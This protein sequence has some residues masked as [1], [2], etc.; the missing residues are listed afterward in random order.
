VLIEK[1][2]VNG[3]KLSIYS[4]D[5]SIL[6][7]EKLP[8]LYTLNFHMQTLARKH[9]IAKGLLVVHDVDANKVAMSLARDED[10]FFID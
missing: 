6:E 4:E 2:R 9:R 10:S 7:S 3:M 1:S 5:L 8:D